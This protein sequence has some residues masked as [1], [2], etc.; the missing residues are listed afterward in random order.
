P[1]LDAPRELLARAPLPLM[2][3]P[4]PPNA[5]LF[6]ELG[7]FRTCWLP[8]RSAPVPRLPPILPALGLRLDMSRVPAPG[9]V[10]R[11]V[12]SRVPAL[13]PV[14]RFDMSRPPAGCCRA[15]FWRAFACRLAIESP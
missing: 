10:P 12:T 7:V 8:T 5:F 11:L 1:M 9:P 3:L 4:A 13:G 2:P 15:T 14:P 6:V